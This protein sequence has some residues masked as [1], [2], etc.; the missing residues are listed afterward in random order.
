MTEKSDL[1]KQIISEYDCSLEIKSISRPKDGYS[2]SVYL[3]TFANNSQVELVVKFTKPDEVTEVIFYRLTSE[4]HFPVPKIFK[5]V[6]NYYIASKLPGVSL[7]QVLDSLTHEQRVDIYRQLGAFVGQ[8]HAKYTFDKCAY[9]NNQYFSSW[10]EMFRHTI[11]KQILQ[12]KGTIFEEL[13][14]KIHQHL[15]RNIHM[16]D[17]EITPRLLHMDLHCGN[18]LVSNGQLT[19]IL[20]AEDALIGH[21][22]YELM[23]IEK[24]HFEGNEHRD[25]FLSSYTK[26]VKLDEGYEQR[27]WFYSLSREIVG[28]QCLI[29]F[30]EQYAQTGSLEEEK[31]I[32]EDK[33]Q[34]IGDSFSQ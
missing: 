6:E 14:N 29:R 3:I 26:Y 21:N 22:E 25:D 34:S 19:G 1:I 28:M 30:G 32:I 17:Y 12:F 31:K 27:R 13:G 9:L 18:I 24:G 7:S 15:T 16:I 23:R 11:E 20:D 5:S 2:N 10:K 4:S 33:I 8:L